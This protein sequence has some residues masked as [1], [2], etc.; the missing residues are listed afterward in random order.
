MTETTTARDPF[1]ERPRDLRSATIRES[2]LAGLTVAMVAVPLCVGIAA[3]SPGVPPWAG[4]LSGIISGLLVGSISRSRT[5]ISGPTAGLTAII[6]TQ[7]AVL[8]SFEALLLAVMFAG[9]LQIIL[10]CVKTGSVAAFFPSSVI[11]GLLFAIGIILILKQ[12]PHVLGHD[13]DPE[14]EMAFLQPDRENTFSEL[15]E[16]TRDVHP[17]AA[18]VGLLSI[19]LMLAWGR[20]RMLQRFPVPVQLIV[21]VLGIALN[22]LFQEIG[23]RWSIQP[24]HLIQ[25]PSLD[26]QR[27][28]SQILTFPAFSQWGNP[29]VYQAGF[30]IAIVAS[31]E[32]LLGLEALAK[33]DPDQRKNALNRELVAQGSGNLCCGLLGGLPITVEIVRSSVGLH[34]GGRSRVTTMTQGILL[35]VLILVPSIV[36]SIPLASVAAVL[37]VTGMQLCDLKVF[38]QMWK[39]GRYQF[40]PFMATIIPIILSDLLVGILI[41]LA[42][43]VTFILNSNLRRPLRRVLERHLGGE[44]LHIE[45]ANQVS[46]LN[47]AVLENTLREVPRGSHVLLDARD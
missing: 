34:S 41:G 37:L 3:I 43:S 14:G 13:T 12:V 16:L 17:G 5:A 44:V 24:I 15:A 20:V 36:N 28:I 47:R 25:L 33:L 29:F 7:L 38:Q 32:S 9:L 18:A 2:V 31:L 35:L 10:G 40:L 11:R 22:L 45:L 1:G 39:S 23:G 46:F 42:I 27:G 8:G 21:I 26:P 30:L 6:A 4:I 19:A